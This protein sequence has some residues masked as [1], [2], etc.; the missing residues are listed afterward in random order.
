MRRSRLLISGSISKLYF[1][2]YRDCLQA[3]MASMISRIAVNR[4]IKCR[5][6]LDFDADISMRRNGRRRGIPA[7]SAHGEAAHHYPSASIRQAATAILRRR[8][9]YCS[10]FVKM[11]IKRPRP[12]S[13]TMTAFDHRRQVRLANS[14]PWRERG[15]DLLIF[16]A[17][18]VLSHR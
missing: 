7:I 12:M 16:G 9:R 17:G 4:N 13:I 18:I 8:P 5:P 10:A 14:R 3:K 11:Q 2:G 6:L 15:V 1:T